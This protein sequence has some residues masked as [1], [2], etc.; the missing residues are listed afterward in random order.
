MRGG[1]RVYRDGQWLHHRQSC[2]YLSPEVRFNEGDR[3]LGRVKQIGRNEGDWIDVRSRRRKALR[4][5]VL[6]QDRFEVCDRLRQRNDFEIRHARFM[7]SSR[8]DR[9][10]GDS[11]TCSDYSYGSMVS[12]LLHR[13]GGET[14]IMAGARWLLCI[15][16]FCV[17]HQLRG[18][19]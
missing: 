7:Y 1:E 4:R 8:D 13:E 16:S 11:D 12:V 9:G 3:V 2:R 10:A 5:E 14:A 6:G 18:K 17:Q 15:N 19:M